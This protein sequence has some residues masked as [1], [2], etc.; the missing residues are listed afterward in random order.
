MSWVKKVTVWETAL[1]SMLAKLIGV[2]AVGY[3]FAGVATPDLLLS[4]HL[5][6]IAL[7]LP[8]IWEAIELVR[9]ETR[10]LEGVDTGEIDVAEKV[11]VVERV[12]WASFMAALTIWLS[13]MLILTLSWLYT[14]TFQWQ[15]LQLIG[16]WVALML[17]P[18]AFFGPKAVQLGFF[19]LSALKGEL[20]GKRLE[21]ALAY[22]LIIGG[23]T[24]F[25]MIILSV[26]LIMGGHKSLDT[27][28][29]QFL[30]AL[31]LFPTLFIGG[32]A[33]AWLATAPVFMTRGEFYKG[34]N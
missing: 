5:L 2:S 27:A 20:K 33:F 34:V 28:L 24:F 22:F 4:L 23:W 14:G 31:G 17:L 9:S 18:M 8:S 29:D 6:A 16:L 15:T 3:V 26:F 21:T 1:V 13:L 30:I 7:L 11:I 10:L 19:V 25:M 12:W 32:V